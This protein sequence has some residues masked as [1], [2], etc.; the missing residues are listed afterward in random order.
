MCSCLK[1]RSTHNLAHYFSD[2]MRESNVVTK[3]FEVVYVSP[4]DFPPEDDDLEFREEMEKERTMVI[5]QKVSRMTIT[6]MEIT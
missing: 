5:K 6:M 2:G 1:D 3:V 4:P